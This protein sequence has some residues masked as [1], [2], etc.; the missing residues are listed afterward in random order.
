VPLYS[1]SEIVD[2]R[3][4][5]C[6][7]NQRLMTGQS[8][9]SDCFRNRWPSWAP[10]LDQAILLKPSPLEPLELRYLRERVSWTGTDL[11]HALGVSS[12][13]TICRWETG[14]RRIPQPTE[15]LFRMLVTGILTNLPSK[16]LVEH[17]KT[18]WR[19]AQAPLRIYLHP[20]ENRYVYRWASP[21]RRLP[22][23]MQ[24]LFW[25]TDWR[26]LDVGR[27]ADYII[28]RILEKGDLEDWNWLRWTYG[29]AR[30]ARATSK[31]GRLLP[32]TAHLWRDL[33]LTNV[34]V[35]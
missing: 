18:S 19:W 6:Y 17:L 9:I 16:Y 34:Q 1:H 7:I 27:H 3:C 5:K 26:R 15:R 22:A 29:E 35:G 21:M 13:V 20:E 24:R 10:L 23:Y 11:A 32:E 14:V 33:L 25:D 8:A 28:T 4:V 30:I 2:L 31:S 12:N